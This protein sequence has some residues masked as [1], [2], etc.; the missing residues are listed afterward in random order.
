V[1]KLLCAATNTEFTF[2]EVDFNTMKADRT[3]YPFAQC[4]RQ[5]LLLL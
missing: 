2:Q 5:V 4:P 3:Q 1:T